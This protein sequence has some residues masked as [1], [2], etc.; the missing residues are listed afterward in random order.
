MLFNE[1]IAKFTAGKIAPNKIYC[2]NDGTKF[3]SGDG[4]K[5]MEIWYDTCK[6]E[7]LPNVSGIIFRNNYINLANYVHYGHIE[8]ITIPY[9]N[10]L[11]P[12][13]FMSIFPNLK[14]LKT[15]DTHLIKEL[16]RLPNKI[17]K[18]HCELFYNDYSFVIENPN[19]DFTVTHRRYTNWF[20][21]ALKNLSIRA[22]IH[23]H[24]LI[25]YGDS[26]LNICELTI[27]VDC[28]FIFAQDLARLFPNLMCLT[29]VFNESEVNTT[30]SNFD[31]LE[32]I[33]LTMMNGFKPHK[34]AICTISDIPYILLLS[35]ETNIEIRTFRT[36][37]FKK[38]N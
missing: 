35:N 18:I 24:D 8:N 11:D 23:M 34:K 22:D 25:K 5:Y 2:F 12:V 3:I 30:I 16:L 37:I 26:G 28:E 4:Y 15:P 33:N 1:Y 20:P 7:L 31:H 38:M 19:I 14:I 21:S 32:I 9:I 29:I 10:N 6:I 27:R 13:H 36:N 17:K